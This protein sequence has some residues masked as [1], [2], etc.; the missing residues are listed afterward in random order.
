M[1]FLQPDS[2]LESLGEMNDLASP[3]AAFVRDCCVIDRVA[4]VTPASLFAAWESWCKTQGRERFVGTL[5]SFSRDMLAVEP[6][7]R[8]KRVRDGGDR[9]R[10]YEGIGLRAGF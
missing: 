4:W 2:G 7:L 1:R 10:V 5:Q 9:Q 8:R 3:V 6:G